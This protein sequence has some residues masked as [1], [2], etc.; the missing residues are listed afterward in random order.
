[1][2]SH[3]GGEHRSDAAYDGL[4]PNA[5]G[6][7]EL[8]QAFA[9]TLVTDFNIGR[10]ELSIPATI[11]PRLT[12]TPTNF[13]AVSAPSGV[14]VT[15]DA[16]YGAFW[17]DLRVRLA[18]SDDWTV[19]YVASTRY[20][21]TFCVA[22]QMWEYQVRSRAGDAIESEWS[23]VVSAV[24]HPETLPAPSRITTHPT[25]GG[26]RIGWDAFPDELGVDRFGVLSHDRDVP[27]AFPAI[28]GMEGSGGQ[29]T[30]LV[31]GHHYN[32]AVQTWNAAGGGLPGGARAVTVGRG[33]PLPPMRLQLSVLSRTTAELRWRGDHAAAGYQVWARRTDSG[34]RS[35]KER[36]LREVPASNDSPDGRLGKALLSGLVPSVW[37]FEFAVSAYNGNDESDIS[38]WIMA[39]P[40]L[41]DEDS[42]NIGLDLSQDLHI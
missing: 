31:A 17:Y 29:V 19:C 21:T 15:W 26:F 42:I 30:R 34:A 7:Y 41:A 16:V 37:H 14:I 38:Q 4:H 13:T 1:M 32:V 12:P 22:G 40:S 36:V 5:L 2:H 9:R 11:P 28:T 39:P 23:D 6:E 27:G 18:G 35:L 24:A 3:I 10:H 20:D 8:A 25:P 33:T